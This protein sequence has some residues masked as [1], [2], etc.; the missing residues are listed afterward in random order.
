VTAFED[1]TAA[2]HTNSLTAAQRAMLL[3]ILQE[4]DRWSS[5]LTEVELD[6]ADPYDRGRMLGLSD[7]VLHA[8]RWS[9]AGLAESSDG[10]TAY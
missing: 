6:M 7:R 10:P 5:L 4:L 9:L 1:L 3:A 8:Y 2:L